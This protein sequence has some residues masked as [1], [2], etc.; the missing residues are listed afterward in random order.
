MP[1]LEHDGASIYCEE[2]GRGFSIGIRVRRAK[3][4][5]RI[6]ASGAPGQPLAERNPMGQNTPMSLTR[7]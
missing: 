4:P 3:R 1:T 7:D 5:V 2:F 6:R